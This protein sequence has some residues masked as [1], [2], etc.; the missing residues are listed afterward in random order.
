LAA[1]PLPKLSVLENYFSIAPAE[2]KDLLDKPDEGPR[3]TLK[4]TPT[5]ASLREHL[6]HVRA[7]IDTAAAV[8]VKIEMTDADGDRTVISFR[9][10]KLNTGIQDRDLELSVPEGTTVTYPLGRGG[11]GPSGNTSK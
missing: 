8:I 9:D 3:L 11:E 1:S 5:D 2:G 10:I 7:L 6:D 4:L